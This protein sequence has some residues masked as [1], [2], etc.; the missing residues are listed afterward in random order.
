MERWLPHR[1]LQPWSLFTARAVY[2]A[3]CWGPSWIS[4]RY[5]KPIRIHICICVYICVYIYIYTYTETTHDLLSSLL[6]S[7]LFQLI[8]PIYPTGNP[9]TYFLLA[10]DPIP[11]KSWPLYFL[12]LPGACLPFSI[13]ITAPLV[14]RTIISSLDQFKMVYLHLPSPKLFTEDTEKFSNK[15]TTPSPGQCSPASPTP[16]LI[17]SS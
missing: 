14:Q 9:D 15:V 6:F 3:A 2:P 8:P 11:S 16:S 10:A 12:N 5:L 7:Q 1:S 13:S 4:Q 17:L